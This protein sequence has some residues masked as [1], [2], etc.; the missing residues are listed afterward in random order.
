MNYLDMKQS[1][2]IESKY[3][4]SPLYQQELNLTIFVR[5]W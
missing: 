1:I 5:D 4:N 2:S 3:Y